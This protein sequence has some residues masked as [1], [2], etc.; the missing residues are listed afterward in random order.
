MNID[1]DIE[2]DVDDDDIDPTSVP[3]CRTPHQ[4]AKVV[5]IAAMLK[6]LHHEA[7]TEPLDAAGRDRLR[8]FHTR[9]MSA[10][11][12]GLA[13]ELRDELQRLVLPFTDDPAPSGAELRIAQAQLVGWL[14]GLF[15]GIHAALPE[16]QTVAAAPLGTERPTRAPPSTVLP[17]PEVKVV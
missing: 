8:E 17:S 9:T 7:R 10:L 14:E 3:V 11:A 16:Q 13:P 15:H 1:I 12:D 6:H 2:A 5:R 4:L